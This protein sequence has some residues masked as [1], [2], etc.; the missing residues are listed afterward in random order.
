MGTL[1]NAIT[2]YDIELQRSLENHETTSGTK[3]ITKY[4]TARR[5]EYKEKY[6]N[7]SFS[8]VEFLD[9]MALTIGHVNFCSDITTVPANSSDISND[10]SDLSANEEEINGDRC[11]VCLLPRTQN[12]ALLHDQGPYSLRIL[13][14]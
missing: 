1:N 6:L 4:K 12:F 9:A 14:T 3:S 8:S 2:D 10:F 11:H 5:N 7:N 13:S